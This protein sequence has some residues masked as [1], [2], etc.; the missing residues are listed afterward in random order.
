M[1]TPEEPTA[2]GPETRTVAI[3]RRIL[4]RD[5]RT[6]KVD[7]APEEIRAASRRM[8]S[9]MRERSRKESAFDDVKAKHKA[10]LTEIDNEIAQLGVILDTETRELDVECVTEVDWDAGEA[11]TRRTDTGDTIARRALTPAERQQEMWAREHAGRRPGESKTGK[12]K[13]PRGRRGR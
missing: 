3:A 7:M 6:L 2:D 9:I 12:E 4:E 1:H 11:V 8:G 10:E 5:Q 13:Q